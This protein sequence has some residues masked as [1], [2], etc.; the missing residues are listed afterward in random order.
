MVTVL[1]A[2]IKERI[3][4]RWVN[5][6]W[7][8]ALSAY[9]FAG[10]VFTV[11]ILFTE[12]SNNGLYFAT[13]APAPWYGFGYHG[14][15]VALFVYSKFFELVDTFLLIIGKRPVMMLQWWHHA[16]VLLYCWHSY[17]TQIG[18]G[19]WFATTMNY[20]VHSVMYFYFGATQTGPALRK[21]VRPFAIYITLIQLLQMVV[22]IFITV[23][24][25]M[26]QLEGRDC[27]VNKTNSILGLAMY[28]SYLI[29]FSKLFVENYIL[30]KEGSVV[31]NGSKKSA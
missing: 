15:F 5:V 21:I 31:P 12:L 13:C 26:F 25:V 14:L 29:L 28:A 2:F 24:A 10:V 19:V 27:N 4:W 6:I 20:C 30:K 18:T 17:T 1:P 11:P 23:R 8:F 9:S 7:N 16:T 3:Y 22:G